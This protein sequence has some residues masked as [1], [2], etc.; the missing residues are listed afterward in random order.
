[1]LRKTLNHWD[2]ATHDDLFY[3]RVSVKGWNVCKYLK[4]HIQ[5]LLFYSLSFQGVCQKTV[6]FGNGHS[7]EQ[8]KDL[9]GHIQSKY[10]GVKYDCNL[11][12]STFTQHGSLIQ[13]LRGKPE[14]VKYD[15]N[16]CDSKFT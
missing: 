15:C 6:M 9:T 10:E 1:M 14:G 11:C 13:H 5:K 12:D 8:K 7:S 16:Q 3:D 4:E 2:P